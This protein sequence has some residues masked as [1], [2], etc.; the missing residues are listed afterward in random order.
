MVRNI[1]EWLKTHRKIIPNHFISLEF[2]NTCFFSSLFSHLFWMQLVRIS[3][4]SPLGAP[5]AAIFFARSANS[6]SEATNGGT[7]PR[8]TTPKPLH[9]P[10]VRPWSAL[11]VRANGFGSA[12]R[13]GVPQIGLF[14]I[15]CLFDIWSLQNTPYHLC[16]TCV[17]L[18][19]R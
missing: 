15:W 13:E 5:R 10:Q 4:W 17:D 12:S 2:P 7:P 1:R 19:T 18:K 16:P 11:V 6:K 8:L 3:K 9:G 14:N